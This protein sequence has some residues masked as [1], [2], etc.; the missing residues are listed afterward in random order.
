MNGDPGPEPAELAVVVAEDEVMTR[1][2]ISHVLRSGGLVVVDEVGDSEALMAAVVHHRPDAVV[3]DVR[4][5]PTWTSEGIDAG[6]RIRAEHPRTAVII[7]SH[8][9]DPDLVMPLVEQSAQVGYLLKDRV[10]QPSTVVDAVR[11]VVA[12]ECVVDPAVV[13]AL[14]ERRRRHDPL[15]RLSDREREVLAQVAEGLSNNEIARR[16]FISPRTVEVHVAQTFAKLGLLEGQ[17]SNRRV[18]AV[19]TF[20]RASS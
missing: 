13:T 4:M 12:G 9:I 10:L 5:P 14:I 11:R 2:G 19:L 8:V 15:E 20:L 7:L 1:V 3:A 6:L 17:S 18:M 16:L